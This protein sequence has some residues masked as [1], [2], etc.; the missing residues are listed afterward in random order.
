[1]H[2]RSN[3]GKIPVGC[4]LGLHSGMELPFTVVLVQPSWCVWCGF[5]KLFFLGKIFI[6]PLPHNYGNS[7]GT[8]NINQKL[9]SEW[10]KKKSVRHENCVG[11][12]HSEVTYD[13]QFWLT[14]CGILGIFM[15]AHNSGFCYP[16]YSIIQHVLVFLNH[17]SPF[18]IF[19]GV[20]VS[21]QLLEKHD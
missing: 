2:F 21:F 3:F 11:N 20:R 9:K 6:V 7:F 10:T 19:L 13:S 8:Y 14:E 5:F 1:M 16:L 4:M 12:P 17:G 18:E 15:E